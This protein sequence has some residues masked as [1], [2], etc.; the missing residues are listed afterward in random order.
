MRMCEAHPEYDKYAKAAGKLLIAAHVSRSSLLSA[1]KR[2]EI[3]LASMPE[4]STED[5]ASLVE[6]WEPL[7]ILMT[8]RFVPPKV[9][10]LS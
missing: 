3:L 1:D 8:K 7:L 10:G 6:A 5:V 9:L 4:L 2:I